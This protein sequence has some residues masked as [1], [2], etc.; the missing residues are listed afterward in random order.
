[1]SSLST[2]VITSNIRH[3]ILDLINQKGINWVYEANNTNVQVKVENLFKEFVENLNQASIRHDSQQSIIDIINKAVKDI[4]CEK[5]NVDVLD[6][7]KE[8]SNKT[9]QSFDKST[10]LPETL[11]AI[12][13]H[14]NDVLLSY[15]SESSNELIHQKV[16]E[17]ASELISKLNSSVLSEKSIAS[18]MENL[19]ERAVEFARINDNRTMIT[20]AE[21]LL[22]LYLDQCKVIDSVNQES[23]S[24]IKQSLNTVI[25]GL[26]GS[27]ERIGQEAKRL[28][29]EILERTNA[30]NIDPIIRMKTEAAL[31]KVIVKELAVYGNDEMIKKAVEFMHDISQRLPHESTTNDMIMN[32]KIRQIQYLK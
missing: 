15:S 9:V 6:K 12:Q 23:M 5:D 14:V 30:D 7:S 22:S 2:D 11:Q 24:A 28:F 25:L 13:Q 17:L 26:V 1:M 29:H 31:Y 20:K 10:V 32:H 4:A 8:L 19:N 27:S 3:K 21:E 18:L 16:V